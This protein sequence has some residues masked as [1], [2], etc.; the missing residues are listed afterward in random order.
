VLTRQRNAV[1][2]YAHAYRIDHFNI[3]FPFRRPGLS[4]LA[5]FAITVEYTPIQLSCH[6]VMLIELA[7]RCEC[8]TPEPYSVITGRNR[9]IAVPHL[10]LLF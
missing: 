1:A 3:I 8:I 4:G 5:D 2:L 9:S 7:T 6:C 10:G